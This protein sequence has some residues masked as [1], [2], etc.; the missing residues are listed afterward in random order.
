MVSSKNGAKCASVILESQGSLS[1]VIYDAQRCSQD[2]KSTGLPPDDHH[3]KAPLKRRS[4]V[5]NLIRLFLSKAPGLP[6]LQR[7]PAGFVLAADY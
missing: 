2:G 7:I 1:E 4:S 6:E 5:S 3:R